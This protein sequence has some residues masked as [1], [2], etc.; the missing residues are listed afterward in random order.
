MMDNTW[1]EIENDFWCPCQEKIGSQI[2]EDHVPE[3]VQHKILMKISNNIEYFPDEIPQGQ[4]RNSVV[5]EF[6]ANLETLNTSRRRSSSKFL[7]GFVPIEEIVPSLSTRIPGLEIY[8]PSCFSPTNIEKLESI[9]DQDIFEFTGK[10]YSFDL[11]SEARRQNRL[12]VSDEYDSYDYSLGCYHNMKPKDETIP[13]ETLNCTREIADYEELEFSEEPRNFHIKWNGS[14]NACFNNGM[15]AE[16]NKNITEGKYNYSNDSKEDMDVIH[17]TGRSADT[18]DGTYPRDM[19]NV[20]I[21][22]MKKAAGK[23][24]YS[25]LVESDNIKL[26]KTQQRNLAE[27]LRRSTLNEKILNLQH[28]IPDIANKKKISKL[29]IIR[30]AVVYIKSLEQE[31]RIYL[32]IRAAEEQRNKQLFM[33]LYQQNIT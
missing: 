11:T 21:D 9:I 5:D 23:L 12:S 15:D 29:E 17:E 32:Q 24:A 27:R 25:S 8:F 4:K 26:G 2:K 14:G 3:C 6:L 7:P 13:C 30:S 22:E 33:K 28:C 16:A 20:I 10:N 31:E 18:S 19:S 1:Y